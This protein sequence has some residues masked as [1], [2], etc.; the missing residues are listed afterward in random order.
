MSV[1][2][3]EGGRRRPPAAPGEVLRER[4]LAPRKLSARDL[5]RDL[6]VPTVRITRILRGAGPVTAPVA[7]LLAR[8]FDTTARFWLDLQSAHDVAWAREAMA[9]AAR[10]GRAARPG[11]DPR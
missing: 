4:F 11:G 5:A 7:I 8:R 1:S 3:A 10:R 9:G 6:G 2:R